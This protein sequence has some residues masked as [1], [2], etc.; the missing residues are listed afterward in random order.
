MSSLFGG[1]KSKSTSSSES[2]NKAYDSINTALSPALG[3]VTSGGNALKALL[4]GD[5]SGLDTYKNSMGYDWTLK[6]GTNDLM[7]KQAAVGGL[8]SGATLKGLASYQTGLNNQYSTNYIQQLL[9]LAGLGTDAASSIAGAGNYNKSTGTATS[10]TSPNIVG[11]LGSIG[12][13]MAA[14]F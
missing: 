13:S 9:G 14:G 7:A 8:D 3:Y 4:G 11:T 10:K 6:N 12:S 5:T 2:Y 1:S